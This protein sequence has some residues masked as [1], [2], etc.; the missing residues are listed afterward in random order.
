VDMGNLSLN[1]SV[2]LSEIKLPEGVTIT[3]FAHGG[4][5]L[6]VA[7]ITAIREEVE[8]APVVEAAPAEGAAAAPAGEAA[9]AEAGKPEAAKKEGGKAEGG[10]K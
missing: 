6:A 10:K 7:A 5:D 2:H 1:Q 9:K 4:D 3:S 8:A